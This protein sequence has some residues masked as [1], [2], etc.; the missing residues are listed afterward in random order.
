MDRRSVLKQLGIAGVSAAGLVGASGTA[1]AACEFRWDVGACVVAAIDGVPIVDGPCSGTLIDRAP[2]GAT[3]VIKDRACCGSDNNVPFYYLDW[4]DPR[5]ED[6][7]VSQAD[8]RQAEGCCDTS[9]EFK[10]GPE[11]CVEANVGSAPV[12]AEPCSPEQIGEV[13]EGANG[14]IRD[15]VCCGEEVAREYYYVDWC[16][17]DLVDGWVSQADLRGSTDCCASTDG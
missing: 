1:A 8:L 6:G 17:P 9:C 4:C 10:W 16:D 3:A 12:L 7:W 13:Y 5:I 11:A 14:V 2:E 15:A